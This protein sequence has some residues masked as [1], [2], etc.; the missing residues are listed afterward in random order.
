MRR[1][2]TRIAV[3]ILLFSPEESIGYLS[4]P[5]LPQLT[6][7]FQPLAN[8][9]D[10][11]SDPMDPDNPTAVPDVAVPP[12]VAHWSLPKP[13]IYPKSYEPAVIGYEFKHNS[14][15]RVIREKPANKRARSSGDMI[16]VLLVCIV[17]SVQI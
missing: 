4:V 2:H 1:I 7:F 13:K 10:S 17:S 15:T 8:M 9:G 14:V 11:A 16:A 5:N 6:V 12:K 3:N